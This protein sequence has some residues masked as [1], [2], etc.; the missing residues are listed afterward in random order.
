[1]RQNQNEGQKRGTQQM[2]EE[3]VNL[4]KGK[5]KNKESR[6]DSQGSLQGAK[7]HLSKQDQEIANQAKQH[8]KA[9]RNR[10]I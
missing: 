7:H 6:V 8:N 5:N 9:G 3:N 10:N 4:E 2:K 1:M